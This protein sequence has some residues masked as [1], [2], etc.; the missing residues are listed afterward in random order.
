MRKELQIQLLTLQSDGYMV[1]INVGPYVDGFATLRQ[2]QHSCSTV[3]YTPIL[4]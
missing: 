1:K 4:N 2:T 3:G